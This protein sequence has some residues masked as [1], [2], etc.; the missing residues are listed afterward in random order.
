MKTNRTI[1][2]PSLPAVLFV[3]C[4]CPTGIRYTDLVA[5][6]LLARG[7]ATT[8]IVQ[9]M[10]SAKSSALVQAYSF[11]IDEEH[12][13]AHDK[14]MIIDDEIVIKDNQ[15]SLSRMSLV[16]YWTGRNEAGEGNLQR[17]PGAA[18]NKGGFEPLAAVNNPSVSAVP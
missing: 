12:A 7:G 6:L 14:V 1:R 13:I 2:A 16:P 5:S 17:D 18:Q 4:K 9:P 10:K 11:F 8:A 15:D 3:L